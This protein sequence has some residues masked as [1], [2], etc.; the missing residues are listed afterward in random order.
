MR[1]LHGAVAT[2]RNRWAI[3]A[4]IALGVLVTVVVGG[5]LAC[6]R[7][8]PERPAATGTTG[9]CGATVDCPPGHRCVAPGKC[10][11]ACKTDGDCPTGRR[12]A[13]LNLMDPQEESSGAGTVTSCVIAAPE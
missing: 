7:S 6:R 3:P 5:R 1:D 8:T 2:T 4:L 11:R 12:C 10:G 9:G 13:E